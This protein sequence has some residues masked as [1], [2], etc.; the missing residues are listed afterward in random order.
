MTWFEGESLT[1]GRQTPQGAHARGDGPA[2]DHTH[3][4]LH[5][6]QLWR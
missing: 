4:F 5:W 2:N 3:D 6:E 1:T